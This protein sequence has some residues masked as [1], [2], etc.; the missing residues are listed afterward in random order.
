MMNRDAIDA[1]A[2]GPNDPYARATA[3]GLAAEFGVD[4]DGAFDFAARMLA[5]VRDETPQP[6]HGPGE[7]G[8]QIN[9][10]PMASDHP[11]LVDRPV[12]PRL[13]VL[14]HAARM[15]RA[16]DPVNPQLVSEKMMIG[17]A[18]VR[19][20]MKALVAAGL[21]RKRRTGRNCNTTVWSVTD[22]GKAAVNADDGPA[23]SRVL[24]WLTDGPKRIA[25]LWPTSPE[26]PRQRVHD[27]L[28]DMVA[29]GVIE[30][31]NA[32]EGRTLYRLP[33]LPFTG[34]EAS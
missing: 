20:H 25:D 2:Q 14:Q 11:P 7:A 30:R 4:P 18:G 9:Y 23:R 24:D 22:A 17:P 26:W 27:L 3:L 32:G 8:G 34:T 10:V 33:S 13:E 6:E 1:L 29:E 19:K 28:D 15:Q 21:M 5:W 31:F 12:G 16:G